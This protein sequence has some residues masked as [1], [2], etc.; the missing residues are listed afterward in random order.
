MI[1]CSRK[2]RRI[3]RAGLSERVRDT[4]GALRLEWF[5]CEGAGE[6][7][8]SKVVDFLWKSRSQL[9]LLVRPCDLAFRREGV[10]LSH[11]AAKTLDFLR[12]S[13]PRLTPQ[14]GPHLRELCDF[15]EPQRCKLS[16]FL[17]QTF[18]Q[19][20][21]KCIKWGAH[22]CPWVSISPP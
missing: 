12:K 11:R 13:V 21:G 17:F 14:K 19:V 20:S 22:L 1:G 5:L 6:P 9:S 2:I 8:W 16:G 7:E 4:T 18:G 3:L 15:S 10:V